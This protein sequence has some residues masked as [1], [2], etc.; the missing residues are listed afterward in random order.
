MLNDKTE[1]TYVPLSILSLWVHCED[2][3]D[4]VT[5]RDVRYTLRIQLDPFGLRRCAIITLY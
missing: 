2:A 4:F 1:I 3:I 5:I